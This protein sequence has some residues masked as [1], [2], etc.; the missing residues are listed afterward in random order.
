MTFMGESPPKWSADS[1]SNPN[2]AYNIIE[3]GSIKRRVSGRKKTCS[4]HLIV[5][6]LQ[7]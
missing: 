2:N 1:P 3:K 6:M 4:D 7:Y 5:I